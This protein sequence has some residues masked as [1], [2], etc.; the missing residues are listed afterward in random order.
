MAVSPLSFFILWTTISATLASAAGL[1][2]SS[3]VLSFVPVCAQPC[4]QSFADT[5]FPSSVCGD[6]PSLQCLCTHTGTLGYTVG[7]G[8]DECIALEAGRGNCVGND[9]SR[10][11]ERDREVSGLRNWNGTC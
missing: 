7:E 11:C 5:S 8:A 10:K 6:A 3:D 1:T 9:G 4:F 2:L